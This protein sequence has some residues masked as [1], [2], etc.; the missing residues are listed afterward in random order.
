MA[1][2]GWLRPQTGGGAAPDRAFTILPPPRS[3]AVIGFNRRAP[4][5]S[6]NGALIHW[7]GRNGLELRRLDSIHLETVRGTEG[8]S[9]LSFWSPDS[10]SFAFPTVAALFRVRLPDGA[11]EV[12]TRLARATRGGT[13]TERGTILFGTVEPTLG[14]VSAAGGEVRWVEVPGLKGGGLYGPEFVPGGEDF[15]FLFVPDADEEASVYLATLRAGK[16]ADPVLLFKNNTAVHYSPASGG[17]IFFVRSDNL[18]AQKLDV[19]GQKVQGDPELV[20]RGV[21]SDPRFHEAHFSVSQSGVVAWHPGRAALSQVTIFDRSGK[22]IGFAGPPDTVNSL[23][24]APDG[25]RLL[26]ENDEGTRLLE[27]G[28]PGLLPFS[29][30]TRWIFWSP[31]GLRLIGQDGS[32][33]IVERI[34]GGAADGRQLM[35]SVAGNLE[36]ISP[37]GKL[38]LYQN[39][40]GSSISSVRLDGA[41]QERAPK[42]VV[43]TNEFIYTPRFSPDGHWIAYC[44]HSR[45]NENLG[46]YVQP[47]PGPGLRRQIA[48]DGRYPVWSKEGKEILYLGTNYR[49]WSVPVNAAAGELRFGAP[50]PL[51]SV[52]PPVNM[53]VLVSPLEVS[54]DGSC[55]YFAQAV[56]QPDADLIHVKMG[57]ES[58]GTK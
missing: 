2:I 29:I 8:A 33:D 49:I 56:E 12:I 44:A 23:R 45:Q 7:R 27:P 10:K 30:G 42:S 5:I 41:A 31:D 21:A 52:R 24:L 18:Y 16:P 9:N 34:S 3:D 48:S 58:A 28:R 32:G 17:R 51:F 38:V 1:A 35:Q 46:I 50:Q 53:I 40:D 37:D 15:L 25:T 54:R 19:K 4:V 36:D 11:P 20:E 43:Q 26:A 22:T 6:P 13:W 39:R 57:W 14:M 55:I 47:F